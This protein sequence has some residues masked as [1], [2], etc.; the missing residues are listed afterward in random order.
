MSTDLAFSLWTR[1][2]HA[3]EGDRMDELGELFS[4]DAELQTSSASGSGVEYVQR[5]FSRHRESYP[6]LRHEVVSVIG[7]PSG[8]S[9]AVEMVFS[10]THCGTLRHPDGGEIPPTG[11]RLTWQATDHVRVADG[12]IV[13]W[14]AYFDRLAMLQQLTAP[15]QDA[16]RP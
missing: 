12:R 11:R 6:D 16:A 15:E 9:V 1:A 2:W 14:H 5:V 10:G 4:P 13:S 7:D 8:Q 3:I